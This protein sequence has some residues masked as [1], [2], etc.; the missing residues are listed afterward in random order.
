MTRHTKKDLIR[1]QDLVPRKSVKT[2]SEAYTGM[3]QGR[4]A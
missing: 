3:G 4:S 2:L 1:R